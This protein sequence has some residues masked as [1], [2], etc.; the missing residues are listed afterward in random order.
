MKIGR[1]ERVSEWYAR[2]CVEGSGGV[3]NNISQ[4][5]IKLNKKSVCKLVFTILGILLLFINI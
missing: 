1:D 2:R 5:N 4:V 3:E